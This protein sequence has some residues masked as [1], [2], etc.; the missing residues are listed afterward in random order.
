MECRLESHLS[1][2]LPVIGDWD[3]GVG[4]DGSAC[5]DS[6]EADAWER[7]VAAAE[8]SVDAGALTWEHAFSGF[9]RWAV[10]TAMA[11]EEFLVCQWRPDER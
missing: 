9:D 5:S 8:E 7:A 11:S 10:G 2:E 4:G 6:W 3:K 1:E